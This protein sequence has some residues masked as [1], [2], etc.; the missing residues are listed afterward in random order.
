MISEYDLSESTD[1]G[2]EVIPP[3]T[4]VQA[5]PLDSKLE[6]KV[7]GQLI[8]EVGLRVDV[9]MLKGAN[10]ATKSTVVASFLAVATKLFQEDLYLAAQRNPSGHRGNGPLDISVHP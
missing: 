10:K 1:V 6:K 4:D 5:A 8:N 9:L 7:L 3:Y 2:F